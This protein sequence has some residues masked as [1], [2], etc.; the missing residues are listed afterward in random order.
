VFGVVLCGLYD[1]CAFLY[2]CL[3]YSTNFYRVISVYD[4]FLKILFRL[5][6]KSSVGN[7]FFFFLEKKTKK[8]IKKFR[9]FFWG[10]GGQCTVTIVIKFFILFL[11]G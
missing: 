7:F 11:N 8:P 10:G 6:Y 1:Y 2:M 9:F 5:L 3:C 4:F